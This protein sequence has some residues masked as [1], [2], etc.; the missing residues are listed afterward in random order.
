MLY[1]SCPFIYTNNIKPIKLRLK[2]WTLESTIINNSLIIVS[3]Y[4]FITLPNLPIHLDHVSNW[5]TVHRSQLKTTKRV[6]FITLRP[7]CFCSHTYFTTLLLNL[8]TYRLRER[9]IKASYCTFM[10]ASRAIN[11]FF[12]YLLAHSSKKYTRS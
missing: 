3:H 4:Y 5:C 8:P 10:L 2:T 6:A 9:D 1:S 7:L 12:G 11:Y